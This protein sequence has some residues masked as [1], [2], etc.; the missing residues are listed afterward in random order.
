MHDAW[1]H[2]VKIHIVQFAVLLYDQCMEA[3]SKAAGSQHRINATLHISIESVIQ[4]VSDGWW[5]EKA[6]GQQ[7]LN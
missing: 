2:L 3:G 4:I 5:E 1:K 7:E 6:V